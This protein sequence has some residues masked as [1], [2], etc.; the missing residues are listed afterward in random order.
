[1][2]V[3]FIS[4]LP[5]YASSKKQPEQN[6]W[7]ISGHTGI[8]LRTPEL[9]G[10]F[11]FTED[12]FRHQPG[13]AFNL[14]FGR[15]IGNQWE[16]SIRWGAYTLFGQSS[17][18]HYSSFGYYAAYPG[19]L[20]Q[21]SLEYITQSNV[22]SFVLR[23][24]FGNRRNNGNTQPNIRPFIEAGWGINN[25][26]TEVR[27][28]KIPAGESAA[29]IFHNR[30]GENANGTAQITTGI[31]FKTGAPGK[32]NAEILIN[33]DWVRFTTL[34]PVSQMLNPLNSSSRTLVSR[35]TAGIIIPIKRTVK[36][37]KY[38]PFRW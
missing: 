35:I 15:T 34:N 18:P 17:L 37:D 30:N 36:R 10:G 33:A 11:N 13:F 25:Y 14:T 29:L 19:L 2:L 8:A 32:W 5:G 26:V 21:E 20:E 6:N 4:P 22:F 7:F 16:P 31:G 23:F 28:S 1:M 27:Y 12:G 9:S 24:L 3:I 38:L